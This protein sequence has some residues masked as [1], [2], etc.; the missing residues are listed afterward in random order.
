MRGYQVNCGRIVWEN[1]GIRVVG[2]HEPL[3]EFC[4]A[5]SERLDKTR[6]VAHLGV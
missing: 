3:H 2:P 4:E 5:Q 1:N 6:P